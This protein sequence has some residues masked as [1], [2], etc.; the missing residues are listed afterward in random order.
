M[1]DTPADTATLNSQYDR[2]DPWKHLRR[3]TIPP[4]P[5]HHTNTDEDVLRAEAEFDALSS[6]LTEQAS[7]PRGGALKK[8][9]STTLAQSNRD[10]EKAERPAGFD[11]R[12]YLTSSN[13][14][15][16]AAGIKHKVS[17]LTP[18]VTPLSQFHRMSASYGRTWKW[19]SEGDWI[20]R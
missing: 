3:E 16:Q 14:K 1:A 10:L 2:D 13:D 15:N 6:H 12:E 9:S 19:K 18:S 11:L 5:H 17:R 20:A 8:T 7:E 4:V